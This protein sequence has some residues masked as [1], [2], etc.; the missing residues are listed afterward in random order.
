MHDLPSGGLGPRAAASPRTKPIK[1][2]LALPFQLA[3]VAMSR[4]V[5]ANTYTVETTTLCGC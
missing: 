1:C 2:N 5:F 3:E 4:Q